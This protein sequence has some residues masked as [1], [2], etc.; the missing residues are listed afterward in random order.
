VWGFQVVHHDLWD[1]DVAA[2]PLLFVFKGTPAI[3][4]AAKTGFV[5]VLNRLTGEPLY[6][7]QERP[8]P[9]SHISGEH[10]S[11]T[12]P[13][14]SLPALGLEVF[15]RPEPWGANPAELASCREIMKS[16]T[17]EGVFTPP[18]IDGIL[19]FPSNVGGVNW[20][21]TAFDPRTGLLYANTNNIAV[22]IKLIPR[23]EEVNYWQLATNSIRQL[24][25]QPRTLT[26][27]ERLQQQ[28]ATLRN[29][30]KG[31]F[32]PQRQ[33]PYFVYREPL[34]AP[35]GLPC[36][37]PPW[38]TLSALNLNS[39]QKAWDVPLGTMLPGMSTGSINLGGPIV[40]AGG[41]VFTAAST[42]PY[43]RAFDSASGRELSKW[44]L[45]APAQATPMT[46]VIDG[47][48]FVVI[49]AGGHGQLGTA[50]ADAVIAF[51]L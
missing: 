46:Y 48:Q 37:K 22:L 12:Q 40:T 43:L 24:F 36:N 34:I 42:D 29:R 16:L 26:L 41:L 49:C 39:G 14:S 23:N 5:F 33:T 3:A 7:I 20:G 2:Q 11:P 19:L 38:G 10:A 50:L 44:L 21:S 18:S 9:A 28:E 31:E 45:P 17:W 25:G 47:K 4:I 8:V 1:Y 27:R 13:F 30:F 35:S 51:S 15:G 6:P 32:S